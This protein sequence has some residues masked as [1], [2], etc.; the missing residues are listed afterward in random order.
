MPLY[1]R[2]TYGAVVGRFFV[3]SSVMG[4]PRA[5]DQDQE[6]RT[7]GRCT[8]GLTDRPSLGH[9]ARRNERGAG[10][11]PHQ[12]GVAQPL[13]AQAVSRRPQRAEVCAWTST[14]GGRR[15]RRDPRRPRKGHLQQAF[16]SVP[17][18]CWWLE[19]GHQHLVQALQVSVG[20]SAQPCVQG[21]SPVD[22]WCV[23]GDQGLRAVGQDHLHGCAFPYP[24][25]TSTV[26]SLRAAGRRLC[27]GVEGEA[28]GVGGGLYNVGVGGG[29]HR[30]GR[31]RWRG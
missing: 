16:C 6:R 31:R 21:G 15:S 19:Q 27:R 22:A 30:A 2:P 12:L 28:A 29:A 11:A 5:P 25:V 23:V 9:R 24:G 4:K 14:G 26:L 20:K 8:S 18:L 3:S 13:A 7:T 1:Q 17:R 10:P